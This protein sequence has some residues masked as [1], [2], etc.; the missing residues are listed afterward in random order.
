M[1]YSVGE[2]AELLLDGKIT[3]IDEKEVDGKSGRQ[4]LVTAELDMFMIAKMN[5]DKVASFDAVGKGLS[6][7]NIKD[8][9]KKAYKKLKFLKK[10]R[11]YAFEADEELK[12]IFTKKSAIKLRE[13]K[14]LYDQGKIKKSNCSTY[15]S[16]T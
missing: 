6:K 11:Q 1:G 15:K 16:N 14:G 5:G 9:N 2:D 8:A 3:I 10:S 12:R 4:F 13:G 7:K